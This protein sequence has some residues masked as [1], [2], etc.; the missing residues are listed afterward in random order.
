[1]DFDV[2]IRKT[3]NI[4]LA[5]CR[6]IRLGDR[7][8]ETVKNFKYLG[9]VIDSRL[10]FGD[11][12]SAT[13]RN[14]NNKLHL[15]SKVRRSV[16][17]FTALTIFKTMV[18]PYLEYAACFLIGCN[19]V[20]RI[21]LQRLQNRGLK[22]ALNKDRLYGTITLH[23]EAKLA[24]WENRTKAALCRLIFKYKYNDDYIICGRETRL[25]DGPVFR[26]DTP[27]TDWYARSASYVSR[28]TFN[29][30]PA[31]IRLLDDQTCFKRA[32]KRHFYNVGEE[33]ATAQGSSQSFAQSSRDNPGGSV[34]S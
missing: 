34:R 4:D 7:I 15:M 25:H 32:L 1:M 30:L 13:V 9:I 24:T 14:V 23:N 22:L 11:Q 5:G 12:L 28:V 2:R 29:A 20:D 19:Q 33:G 21:K 31:H 17:N 26:V 10:Q 3:K 6:T 8:V 18:L 27:K 16:N